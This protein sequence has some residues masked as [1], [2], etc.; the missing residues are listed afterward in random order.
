MAGA[1]DAVGQAHYILSV[2]Y[3]QSVALCLGNGLPGQ[4][5]FGLSSL[6][7]LKTSGESQCAARHEL[8]CYQSVFI[9][10]YI[11]DGLAHVFPREEN[12]GRCGVVRQ[13]VVVRG[14]WPQ[15]A[16]QALHPLV[17]RRSVVAAY[18]LV[19]GRDDGHALMA[20]L[21][22]HGVACPGGGRVIH[23][24]DHQSVSA[25]AAH[26]HVPS[27]GLSVLQ[28][29]VFIGVEVA[30]H[31]PSTAS[32]GK[33]VQVQ[34]GGFAHCLERL[35]AHEVAFIGGVAH[36]SEAIVGIFTIVHHAPIVHA[37]A[38]ATCVVEVGQ[39]QCMAQ[40]VHKHAHTIGDGY[41]FSCGESLHAAFTN[42]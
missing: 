37:E 15:I 4:C 28:D 13:F 10:L 8:Q 14:A 12:A 2:K 26:L 25:A 39:P 3:L 27:I 21:H 34:G 35:P 40:L 30:H 31:L 17:Q 9:F 36:G 1:A 19:V 16:T 18:K 20:G 41:V 29:V 11:H 22:V 33:T 7:G 32:L 42:G 38:C 24:C 23:V 6:L 5:G